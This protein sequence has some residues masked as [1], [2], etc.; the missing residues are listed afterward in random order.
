M[1]L[2]ADHIGGDVLQDE[3]L[4]VGRHVCAYASENAEEGTIKITGAN[5]MET[6][7]EVKIKLSDWNIKEQDAE[8][9]VMS[10]DY[11]WTILPQE[12]DITNGTIK[13]N[14]NAEDANADVITFTAKPWSVFHI[15]VKTK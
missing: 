1:G 15:T 13:V 6:E 5:R 12:Y 4:S 14:S 11:L 10:S 9:T 7:A 3:R 8:I 2:L